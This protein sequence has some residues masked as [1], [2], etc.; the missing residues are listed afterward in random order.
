MKGYAKYF[1][2]NLRK[3]HHK[4]YKL[5]FSP[6]VMSLTCTQMIAYMEFFFPDSDNGD[7]LS[8]PLVLKV[9]SGA[10]CMMVVVFD[11]ILYHCFFGNKVVERLFDSK[12]I[13]R[14]LNK[15]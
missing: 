15:F 12:N 5:R 13:N 9:I 14:D 6:P 4:F 8:I 7:G 11:I 2:N 3:W 10:C 1:T